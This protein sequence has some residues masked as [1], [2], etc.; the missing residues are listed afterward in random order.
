MTYKLTQA[1]YAR[2]YGVTE[3]SI[4]TYQRQDL[5]L[6]EP[7]KTV[8]ILLDRKTR[9]PSF[10]LTPVEQFSF[11]YNREAGIEVAPSA[12]RI[13]ELERRIWALWDAHNDVA[14]FVRE[15]SWPKAEE[16]VTAGAGMSEMVQR[17]RALA[18]IPDR[19]TEA[20]EEEI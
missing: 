19:Q 16:I 15:H 12:A 1:Q 7:G 14:T 3:R 17:M 6:D 4:R 9:P 5:P 8:L 18:G 10:A 2:I 11:N 13:S 20:G